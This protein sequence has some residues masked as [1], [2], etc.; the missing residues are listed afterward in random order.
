MDIL[1]LF[2]KG[3]TDKCRHGAVRDGR[4]QVHED[5]VAGNVNV[6]G[7]DYSELLER[8]G[9][10]GVRDRSKQVCTQNQHAHHDLKEPS[11]STRNRLRHTAR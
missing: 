3:L 11:A 5:S 2:K 4:C 6:F 1:G 8:D 10:F 7:R 9:M